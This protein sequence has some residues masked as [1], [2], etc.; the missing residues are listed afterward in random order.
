MK[1]PAGSEPSL[2]GPKPPANAPPHPAPCLAAVAVAQTCA[3]AGSCRPRHRQCR[4]P[5]KLPWRRCIERPCPRAC[6]YSWSTEKPSGPEP[7]VPRALRANSA[8]AYPVEGQVKLIEGLLSRVKQQLN[9]PLEVL[10]LA[11]RGIG[12]SPDLCRAV[13]ALDWHYLFRVTCQTKVVTDESDYTIAQQVQAGEIW[14]MSGRIFKKRG[15]IPAHARALWEVGYDEPWALVTNDERLIGHEY[16]RRNWQEQS[17]RDLKSGGW[18]WGECRIR[19]PDHLSRLLLLLTLAYGWM[20]ALG[21]QAVSVDYCQP[22]LQ[23]DD[24]SWRR[25][26]S[27]F[28]EGLRFFIDYVRRFSVCLG[29]TFIPDKRFT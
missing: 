6:Q 18:H 16:A 9:Q 28:K 13:Q 14:G 8:A 3:E 20:L 24:G 11:D 27:L 2:P 17:F 7:P 10:V 21:S 12:T 1:S 23:R 15:Q 25:Q 4:Q 22:L 5:A 19:H 29:L 26:W